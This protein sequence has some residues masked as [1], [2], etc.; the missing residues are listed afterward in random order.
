MQRYAGGKINESNAISKTMPMRP[1]L[2]HLRLER[3][4]QGMPSSSILS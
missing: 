4:I 2:Y 1:V 3:T